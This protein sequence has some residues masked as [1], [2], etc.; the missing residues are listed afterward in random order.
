MHLPIVTVPAPSLREPSVDID[1]E[2]LASDDLQTF[3]DNMIPTMYDD[4][5]IGLAAPQVGRNVRACIIGKDADESLDDDL[6][7]INPVWERKN[8]KMNKDTEACLS[9]PNMHGTVARYTHI[10]VTALDRHGNDI[11]F[12]ASHFFARVIQHE[13]DHLDG[14]LYIDKATDIYETEPK[15]TKKAVAHI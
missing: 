9:I 4:D 1:R 7:L 12:D 8:K 6:V 3:L 10:A 13:V 11:A 14:V 2:L 5:G 15:E